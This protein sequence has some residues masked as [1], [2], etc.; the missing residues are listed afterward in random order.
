ML[1][2]LGPL[3]LS[4]GRDD[5]AAA[6]FET[7]HR[8]APEDVVAMN[9]LAWAYRSSNTARALELI[10]KALQSVPDNAAI[11]DTHAMILLEKG[12]F[13]E[14]LAVNQKTLDAA[15]DSP[16]FRFHRAQILAAAERPAEALEL[17]DRPA[18]GPR[19]P[20]GRGGQGPGGK[21]A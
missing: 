9:N 5:D 17:L 11:Q 20:G 19:V 21:V 10:Q 3:Y 13:D 1:N 4:Q 14:A 15:P 16:Q 6:V 12:D 2:T 18:E 7:L 8:L